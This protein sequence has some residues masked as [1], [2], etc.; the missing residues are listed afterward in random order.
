MNDYSLYKH[1][2]KVWHS[3]P[4]YYK[5]GYKLCLAVYAN[6]KGAGAGTHVSVELLQMK[7]EHDGK[8]RWDDHEGFAIIHN[9][10]RISIQMM[11]QSKKTRATDKEFSLDSHFCYC[12]CVELPPPED[13]RVFKSLGHN[14]VSADKFID[15][16]SAEQVMVLNDTI[17]LRVSLHDPWRK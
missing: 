11:V 6:G 17:A 8:L 7:G 4:F 5:D 12:C 15:Y 2:G 9:R 14:A 16:Q 3:P 1:T 13:L 10:Q